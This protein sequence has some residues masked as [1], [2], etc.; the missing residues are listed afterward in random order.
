MQKCCILLRKMSCIA[1]ALFYLFLSPQREVAANTEFR[2]SDSTTVPSVY[3]LLRVGLAWVVG[4]T[5]GGE[6]PY[7]W[8][9]HTTKL[10]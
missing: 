8:W 3:F 5:L 4:K 9:E 10:S 2:V 7:S 6:Y 1:D